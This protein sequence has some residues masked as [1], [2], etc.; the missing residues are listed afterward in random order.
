MAINSQL[1]YLILTA[2]FFLGLFSAQAQT[3]GYYLDPNSEEP[4]FIQRLAWSGGMYSL[5]YE[6][7]IEKEEYGEYVNY[8]NKSVTDNYFDISLSPGNY[9]FRVIPFDVLNKPSKGTDWAPFKVFNAVRPE[10]YQPGNELDYYNDRQGCKF[11]LNGK[12]IEPD[13]KIYF[14]NSEGE[15]IVPVETIRN[16]D[17]NSVR[18]VFDKGQL[19]DGKYDIFIVNP[20]GLETSLA[21]INYRTYKEKFGEIHY[22]A[23]ISFIPAFNIYGEENSF[24]RSL[25][26]LSARIGLNA[27]IVSNKYFGVEFSLSRFWKKDDFFNNTTSGYIFGYNLIFINWLPERIGAINL[28]AGVGFDTQ[29]MDINYLNAGL[30]FLYHASKYLNIEAG[31]DYTHKINDKS[32]AILPWVGI[33]LIF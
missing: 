2:L 4:R 20:G 22:T 13:A 16:D 33:S 25:Y 1:K 28:K 32:G 19:V 29:I 11:Y 23:G 24:G 5:H 27:C 30:Y 15:H 12:N 9:R 21:G 18:L 26:Y 31:A 7:I 10:L 8:M 17:G 3:A 14:V 6:I